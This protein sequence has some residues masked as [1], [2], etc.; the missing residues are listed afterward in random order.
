M[1]KKKTK[2]FVLDTSVL[3]FENTSILNFEE[4]D[5][6]IPITVLEELD[7][8]KKGNDS[9]NFEAREVARLLDDLAEGKSLD[10]WVSLGNKGQGML[11]VMLHKS[12][13]KG[14][15]DANQV[16][17]ER[18][19]DHDILNCALGLQ[20]EFKTNEVIFSNQRYQPKTKS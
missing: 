7:R 19:N 6:V 20:T 13:K 11:K 16:F 14:M 1:P 18:K 10:D 9:K 2:I 3:L 4:H 15:V 12:V 17:G 8:F 5:V